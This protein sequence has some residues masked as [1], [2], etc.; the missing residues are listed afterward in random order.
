VT[1]YCAFVFI[2]V[3]FWSWVHY[4]CTIFHFTEQYQNINNLWTIIWWLNLHLICLKRLSVLITIK[5]LYDLVEETGV[6]TL[7][8]N[9][10][11]LALFE[12]RTHRGLSSSFSIVLYFASLKLSD[13][14][15]S[16]NINKCRRCGVYNLQ[17]LT[18]IRNANIYFFRINS[19]MCKCL[20][21]NKK[22]VML[23]LLF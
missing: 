3:Y 7:S 17:A 5:V 4:I 8:Y 12:I 13:A 23:C 20:L 2:A 14:M 22:H 15:L 6:Q 1:F 10:V 18:L 16:W 9:V 11:H 21:A 19:V